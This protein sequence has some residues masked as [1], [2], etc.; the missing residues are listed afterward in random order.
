MKPDIDAIALALQDVADPARRAPMAAYMRDQ[1]E[2]LGIVT[3]ARRAAIKQ[4][5]KGMK[6]HSADE[7]I[8]MAR[9][10]WDC[11]E[12]EY[13]YA[14]IDLLA[15][16]ANKLD[17][18]HL[19]FLMEL[20]QSKSWWDTVDAIASVVGKVLRYGHD[21]MDQAIGHQNMWVRRVAILHQL[22]WRDKTDEALLFSYS[23]QRAHEKEFFIQKAIGWALRDYARHNPQAVREFTLTEKARLSPLSY[24]EANKHFAPDI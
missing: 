14:A 3:P 4:L 21:G 12:R 19:P 11:A 20:V 10:L 15:M 5:Y 2:F 7:L 22:G 16:H 8:V 18:G 17:V 23:L 1:F 24:R 13:Q 6:S 9:S